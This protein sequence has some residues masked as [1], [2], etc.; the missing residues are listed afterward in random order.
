LKLR[1]SNEQATVISLGE[2]ERLAAST[3]D[4]VAK[5]G[6]ALTERAK[7]SPAAQ[8]AAA[9]AAS[10]TALI[11][12]IHGGG[13][14]LILLHTVQEMQHE[15]EHA[16]KLV[17]DLGRALA[18]VEVGATQDELALVSQ[19]RSVSAHWLELEARS[20]SLARENGDAE[21][22]ELS[23]T[24][25][26]E[27]LERGDK[28]L[29]ETI[30]GV[31]AALVQAVKDSG[32][33]YRQSRS[34]LIGI[35]TL[36]VI[37][38]LILVAW[39]INYLVSSLSA[40][41]TLAQ[42]VANGD[43]TSTVTIKTEDEMGVTLHALNRMS[44]TLRAVAQEVVTAASNVAA[45][46]E[47][48][49]TTAQQLSEGANRQSASAQET[50]SAMEEMT[51][52]I[53]QNAD[54]ARQTDQIAAKAST[55][56]KASGDAVNQ[57][58]SA[59]KNIAEKIGIIEEIARKTDLLA[60]NAAVEAARAG[61][62][63]KGFAVVA[64]EV[65]KLAERSA[66]AAA[67]ISQLSRGGVSM[68][69]SAGTMLNVLVPDIRRTA[70]LVQEIANASAEQSTGVE[71]A[72]TALRDLDR[73]IQQNAS[74]SEQMAATAEQLSA[75]AQQLQ[76][77]VSFFKLESGGRAL[78]PPRGDA[79]KP[80]GTAAAERSAAMKRPLSAAMSGG[81]APAAASNTNATGGVTLD[82]SQAKTGTD[83][84][85]IFDRY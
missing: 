3:E 71:Q 76:A 13:L 9:G 12:A 34:L 65:R 26:R 62:Y 77:T 56:G 80:R 23:A 22:V 52:S 20:R 7:Q 47:E 37:V 8:R 82:M 59:M 69:E 16:E 46:S 33:S 78:R 57:T 74:A 42:A 48:M 55:D 28:L 79:G 29:E 68:A 32:E 31:D 75:Q 25:S 19:L 63:G 43:L 15:M 24:K 6:R 81:Q 30:A 72:N 27:L 84:E 38:G 53:Q 85:D 66:T 4:L 45:G 50:T 44:D 18:E 35:A 40:A 5:L 21:A 1:A 83:D 61:E 11:P 60:L 39:F 10:A 41:A 17:E 64:S 67:E 2:A 70:Q 14:R 73:V 36:A 54:N 49:S 58:A 51:S